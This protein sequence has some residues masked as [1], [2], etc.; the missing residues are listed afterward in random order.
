MHGSMYPYTSIHEK[1]TISTWRDPLKPV[2]EATTNSKSNASA[3]RTNRGT[4]KGFCKAEGWGHLKQQ[5][6]E[7]VKQLRHNE[8][9][10][11]NRVGWE[12]TNR[13]GLQWAGGNSRRQTSRRA[14]GCT[15]SL[16]ELETSYPRRPQ[17]QALAQDDLHQV[18]EAVV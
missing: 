9:K 14:A 13:G 16:N 18:I 7:N 1:G 10:A 17:P 2:G 12:R 6:T 4:N 5:S 3:E 11:R 15:I 8:M